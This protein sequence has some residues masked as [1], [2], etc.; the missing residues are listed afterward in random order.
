VLEAAKEISQIPIYGIEETTFSIA[1][2][3]GNKFGILTEKKHKEA[4]KVQHVRKHGL[5][6]RFAGVRAL[7][8][9]VVEIAGEPEKVKARGLKVGRQLIEEDGAE[10]IILKPGGSY[11][12]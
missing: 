8:M 9:G 10:V 6:Q 5:E 11:T 1:L 12:L 4:V 2:L 7:D 3:L